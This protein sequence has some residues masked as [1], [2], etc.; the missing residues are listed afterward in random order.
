LCSCLSANETIDGY[1]LSLDDI[2]IYSKQLNGQDVYKY[3]S[4]TGLTKGKVRFNGGSVRTGVLKDQFLGKCLTLYEQ[5]EIES[6]DGGPFGE[7]GD[8][9][10]L[11]FTKSGDRL[12]VIGIV[13]GGIGNTCMVTPIRDIIDVLSEFISFYRDQPTDTCMDFE[14]QTSN[15]TL[16]LYHVRSNNTLQSTGIN[17]RISAEIRRHTAEVQANTEH[18]FESVKSELTA[19]KVHFDTKID[20]IENSNREIIESLKAL[21]QTVKNSYNASAPNTEK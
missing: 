9:G 6:A 3:G 10:A 20:K 11:V 16:K 14:E 15:I 7:P 18:K 12:F 1:I 21:S 5:I 13:E 2:D 19:I 8:S 4:K 17:R